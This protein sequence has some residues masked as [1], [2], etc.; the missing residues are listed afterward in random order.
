MSDARRTI[1]CNRRV[2]NVNEQD[3]ELVSAL[4]REQEMLELIREYE[5]K[6]RETF[7][8]LCTV[9]QR[10]FAR[11]PSQRVLADLAA[12]MDGGAGARAAPHM[13]GRA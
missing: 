5:G 8:E 3:Q 9:H 13:E 12:A 11:P 4:D 10:V 1:D 6:S 7:R 2:A